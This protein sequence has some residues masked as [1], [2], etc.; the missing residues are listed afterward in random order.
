MGNT[1][2]CDKCGVSD[3]VGFGGGVEITLDPVEVGFSAARGTADIYTVTT[4]AFDEGGSNTVTSL[5]GYAEFDVGSLAFQRSLIVG[6]GLHRTEALAE[7]E[8]FR[9]HTQIAAYV[10]YPLGFDAAKVKLVLSRSDLTSLTLVD[11]MNRVFTEAN[12]AMSA[13]RLRF[14]YPF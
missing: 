11:E 9:Q 2:P 3:R 7:N 12:S 1:V 14:A 4:G 13:A 8:N 5:G 10:A 6:F